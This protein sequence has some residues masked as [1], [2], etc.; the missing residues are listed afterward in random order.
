MSFLNGVVGA[1]TLTAGE[2]AT[3]LL[4]KSFYNAYNSV[5]T[6]LDQQSWPYPVLWNWMI[7][8]HFSEDLYG[9][10][11]SFRMD[12]YRD[13]AGTLIFSHV[14]SNPGSDN[15]EVG[16]AFIEDPVHNPETVAPRDTD[17]WV[18]ITMLTGSV[19]ISELKQMAYYYDSYDNWYNGTGQYAWLLL[20]P[21]EAVPLPSTV[22]LLGSGL[23]GLMG[24]RRFRRC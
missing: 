3:Y 23:L 10:G 13:E 12:I 2:S 16:V 15:D 4:D 7:R 9:L 18:N 17:A 21:V 11:G 8:P 22:L 14:W 19:N 20:Q 5:Y 6:S 24:W 1:F